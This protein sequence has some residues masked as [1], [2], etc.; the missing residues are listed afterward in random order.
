MVGNNGFDTGAAGSVGAHAYAAAQAAVSSG[1]HPARPNTV[2]PVA[3]DVQRSH[4]PMPSM[5]R[6]VLV[7]GSGGAGKSTFAVRLGERAG[8]PV[9]HL[10][11]L[12]WHAGWVSTPPDVWAR[13]VAA[14]LERDEWVMD[15]NYGGTLDARLA[16]ADTVILLDLPRLVCLWRV[17]RRWLRHRGSTRPDMAAGC[18]EQ[19]TLEFLWWVWTYP[20][21]RRPGILA[22]VEGRT[23]G[24]RL[25]VLRSRREIE[26]FLAAAGDVHGRAQP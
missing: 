22:K 9:I 24:Q 10:D 14:L 1:V 4:E 12:Y 8:L 3:D 26:A 17:V 7:I 18:D 5:M 13:T 20:A 2:T 16:A 23:G 25:V 11:A 19:L 15:G 21:R 6:R